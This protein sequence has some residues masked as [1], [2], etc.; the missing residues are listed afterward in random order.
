MLDT[1]TNVVYG[2]Y[3]VYSLP[4]GVSVDF[5]KFMFA[6]MKLIPG[7]VIYAYYKHCSTAVFA[8]TRH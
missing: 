7:Y 1:V 2:R 6:T 5:L 8:L 3:D 4:D